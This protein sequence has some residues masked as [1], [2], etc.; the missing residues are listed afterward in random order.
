M[1]VYEKSYHTQ[2]KRLSASMDRID[3]LTAEKSNV[4]VA[5]NDLLKDYTSIRQEKD[6]LSIENAAQNTELEELRS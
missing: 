2:E 5:H 1:R 4:E 3:A 6:K